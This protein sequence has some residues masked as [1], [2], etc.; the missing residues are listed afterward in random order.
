MD[1]P[2]LDG[3]LRAIRSALDGWSG[4]TITGGQLYSL[5]RSAAPQL[6][7]RA[8]VNM[9]QGPGALAAFVRRHLSDLLQRFGNQ[10]ADVVYRID[11]REFTESPSSAFL[12][13]WRTFVSPSS[14]QHLVI[15]R[16]A[17]SL[18][19]RDTP[20]SAENGELELAKA[21]VS[22]HDQMRADFMASM[23]DPIVETMMRHVAPEADF[24][25]WISALRE[26]VPDGMRQW[27]QY[28]RER[29]AKLFTDRVAG[30]GLD[31]PLRQAVLDQVKTAEI[32]AYGKQKGKAAMAKHGESSASV[33]ETATDALRKA[34]QL[35]HAA[36]DVLTYNEL[37]ALRLPLGAMLD[38]LRAER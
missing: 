26:H 16:S 6:D 7:I 23:P 1:N 31:E 36:V 32:A 33:R 2:E 29:L 3:A 12:Q 19:S 28:R 27:G 5:V 9:P 18:I 20:A 30:L 11:G 17:R 4:P 34:R 21:S 24:A 37:R 10:G 38:A 8:L 25:S 15:S 22:E 14:P 35:A 13:I